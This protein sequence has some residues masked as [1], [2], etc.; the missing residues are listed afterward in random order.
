MILL[1]Q[2]TGKFSLPSLIS[3]KQ[4]PKTPAKDMRI[5]FVISASCS[6]QT[7]TLLCCRGHSVCHLMVT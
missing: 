2:T 6:G 4:T 3:E 5:I 1:H 7:G